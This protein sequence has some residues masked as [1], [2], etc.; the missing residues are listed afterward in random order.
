MNN[1][2]YANFLLIAR[3]SK[4]KIELEKEIIGNIFAGMYI[5]IILTKNGFAGV[6]ELKKEFEEE[7]L[8]QVR[9]DVKRALLEQEEKEK[10]RYM[11][12]EAL[13]DENA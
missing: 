13:K 8:E 7:E 11:I 3:L 12:K 2:K 1:L 5:L 6:E 4:N 10:I 9:K